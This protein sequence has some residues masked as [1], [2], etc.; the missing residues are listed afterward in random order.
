MIWLYLAN[1]LVTILEWTVPPGLLMRFVGPPPIIP[2]PPVKAQ[3]DEP[4]P[5]CG[6]TEKASTKCVAAPTVKQDGIVAVCLQFTCSQ[7]HARW[8][9]QPVRPNVTPDQVW[10]SEILKPQV[11]TPLSMLN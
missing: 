6:H 5:I 1:F 3:L 8:F 2:P 10:A 9:L 7:C 11:E 4:C